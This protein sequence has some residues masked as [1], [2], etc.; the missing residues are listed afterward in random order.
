VALPSAPESSDVLAALTGL[1]YSVA[2][3]TKAISR[4][5]DS[6]GLSLE[7]KIRMALQQ[8]SGG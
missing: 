6:D 2:E 8:L 3:A 7:E 5:S 4:L 1:G